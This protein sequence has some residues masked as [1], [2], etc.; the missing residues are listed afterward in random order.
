[1]SVGLATV[2]TLDVDAV[3]TK[4]ATIAMEATT[5]MN[6]KGKVSKTGIARS[7]LAIGNVKQPQMVNRPGM[8]LCTLKKVRVRKEEDTITH[9]HTLFFSLCSVLS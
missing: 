7:S 8:V 1:M 2:Q 9:N 6:R 3:L 5:A 4:A